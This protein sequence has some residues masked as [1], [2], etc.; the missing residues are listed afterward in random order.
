[1]TNDQWGDESAN[2]VCVERSGKPTG[3]SENRSMAEVSS[4]GTRCGAR[5]F[6]L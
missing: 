1:M 2:R 6:P 5:T 3:P 4:R